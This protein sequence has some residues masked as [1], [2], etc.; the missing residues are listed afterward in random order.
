[1]CFAFRLEDFSDGELS[2]VQYLFLHLTTSTSK[3]FKRTGVALNFSN[4]TNY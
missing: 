2:S 3:R 1:M 4:L